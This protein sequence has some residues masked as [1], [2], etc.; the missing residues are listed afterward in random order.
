[1]KFASGLKLVCNFDLHFVYPYLDI[2]AI[3]YFSVWYTSHGLS[4][5]SVLLN[6]EVDWNLWI[7]FLYSYRYSVN[8]TILFL[9]TCLLVGKCTY[10]K[11]DNTRAHWGMNFI[12]RRRRRRTFEVF[13]IK[14]FVQ[15]DF[16]NVLFG[17]EVLSLDE[18]LWFIQH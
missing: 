8:I 9:I 13:I 7:E 6:K 10:H 2:S 5:F 1:M 12:G 15:S 17:S 11:F 3:V 18:G 14:C 4:F 16:G